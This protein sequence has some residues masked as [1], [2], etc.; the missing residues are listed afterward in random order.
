MHTLLAFGVLHFGFEPAQGIS[1]TTHGME[2]FLDPFMELGVPSGVH[3][4]K[5]ESAQI[6]SSGI[7]PENNWAAYTVIPGHAI[8]IGKQGNSLFIMD[9]NY[10][11]HQYS[12]STG[13]LI[14]LNYLYDA[15]RSCCSL[16]PHNSRVE[17]F[18]YGSG[19]RPRSNAFSN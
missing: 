15:Y 2:K 12:D 19:A 6:I 17:L 5:Q 4:V 7:F 8:A 9:P 3:K 14:D 13:F 1:T 18:F 16:S 10:G 11:L